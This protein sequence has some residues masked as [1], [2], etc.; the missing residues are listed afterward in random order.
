MG[1]PPSSLIADQSHPP[2]TQFH[3]LYN[4][5]LKIKLISGIIDVTV[6]SPAYKL[7]SRFYKS[8]VHAFELVICKWEV[9][10]N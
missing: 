6:Q 7:N 5:L 9:T 4:V 2:F 1:I 8:Q 3:M 10:Y